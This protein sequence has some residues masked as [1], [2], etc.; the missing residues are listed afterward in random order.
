MLIDRKRGSE[1]TGFQESIPYSD[2]F[3]MQT[4]FAMVYGL[5]YDLPGRI[6]E[7]RRHGYIVH[8]MTGVSWGNY[9]DYLDGKFDGRTHWDEAQKNR[10]GQDVLHGPSVPYMIPTDAFADY[11][12]ERIKPAVD[13]GVFDIHVEEPEIWAYSGYSE[14]IK[15]EYKLYYHEDWTPPHENVDAYY[16]TARLKQHLFTRV[17]ERVAHALKEYAMVKYGRFLS[18]YIPTHSLINYYQY[19]IVSPESALMDAPSVD[20]YIAQVWTDT[21]RVPTIYRGALGERIFESAFLEYGLMQELVRGT[22][23]KMW[24]LQDPIEDKPDET[25]EFYR[26]SYLKGLT[27]ALL[28][29]EIHR[30]EV[31]PWP[32][33]VWGGLYPKGENGI[34][35]PKDYE[36]TLL[37]VSQA[38]RDMDQPYEWLGSDTGVGVLIADSCMF[39]R[40]HPA[41]LEL[42]SPYAERGH[43]FNFSGF[44][45]LTM[46]LLK[47]G[48]HVLPVQLENITRFAD[49][50]KPYRLLVLS[51]EFMKPEQPGINLALAL[52]VRGGGTLVIVSDGSDDFHQVDAWWRKCGYETPLDHLYEN[53]GIP[54]GDGAYPCGKGTVAVMKRHPAA[55]AY[56]ED[57]CDEYVSLVEEQMARSGMRFMAKNYFALRRGPYVVAHVLD[58]AG[59]SA[60]DLDGRFVNLYDP[61]LA[62]MNGIHLKPGESILA[63]DL[64]RYDPPFCLIGSAGRVDD[65][66]FDGKQARFTVKAPTDAQCALRFKSPRPSSVT[67]AEWTYDDASGTMLLTLSGNPD[68]TKIQIDL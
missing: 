48:I 36:T 65:Y 42:T 15:R 22:G 47:R 8:L 37:S 35:L 55:I 19:G 31:C 43:E 9:Q 23:R 2:K 18:F 27:A 66:E 45:G 51:Y 20:G 10:D 39:Q 68:G 49:Y 67:G 29:P 44:F 61:S 58:D 50:L 56:R 34:P 21:S 52:W 54:D 60:F 64:S 7:Y 3:S 11:L 28:Q 62:V 59:E 46:P 41:G 63:A 33:R 1:Y 14:A 16:K 4:D 25:W 57:C 17:I 24:L 38:L 6:R 5:N 40:N 13:E 53:L 30:Y 12:V 32:R 26:A